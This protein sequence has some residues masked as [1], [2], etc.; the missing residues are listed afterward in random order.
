MSD[1]LAK[2]TIFATRIDPRTKLLI[3]VLT[4]T[5]AM[6]A[7]DNI[8]M[9]S[10]SLIVGVLLLLSSE[11]RIALIGLSICLTE[12]I[13][14][15]LF[16]RLGGFG[17]AL[18]IFITF[19]KICVPIFM[20]FI[21]VFKTSTVSAFMSALQKMKVPSSITI[22]I[23]VIFRFI[24]TLKEQWTS[25]NRAMAF[26]GIDT[27]VVGFFKNPISYMEYIMIPML[28]TAVSAMDELA[29]AALSRGFDKDSVRVCLTDVKFSAVDFILIV[30]GIS[31]IFPMFF[32]E[33]I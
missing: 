6:S 31:Y 25:I 20:S 11:K 19:L 17:I 9:F 13:P 27:G 30:V 16:D 10:W 8:I 15:S 26:R 5:F 33:L 28:V 12:F 21:L 18:V 32:M 3:F 29:A 22:P 1:I 23:A 4:F 14:P 2:K 24:P 7:P